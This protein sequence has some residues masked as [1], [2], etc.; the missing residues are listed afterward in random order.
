MFENTSSPVEDLLSHDLMNPFGDITG[1]K[2]ANQ[3][4]AG[5]L[6]NLRR[7]EQKLSGERCSNINLQCYHVRVLYSFLFPLNSH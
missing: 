2:T 7:T 1:Y 3:E 5:I 4:L 6:R